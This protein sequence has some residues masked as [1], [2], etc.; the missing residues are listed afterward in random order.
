M[1]YPVFKMRKLLS[2]FLLFMA[3]AGTAFAGNT[4]QITIYYSVQAIDEINIDGSSVTLTVSG[5]A[6]GQSPATATA[7]TTYDITTNGGSDSKKLTAAIDTDMPADATLILDVTGPANGI[8]E[9]PCTI[10]SSPADVVTMIGSVAQSDIAMDFQLSA[11]PAAGAVSSGSR[12]LTLTL[13]D[14]R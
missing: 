6:A 9:G 1:R 5:A 13:A 2:V 7:A 4:A 14:Q 12:T 10:T 3:L 11:A 8:S